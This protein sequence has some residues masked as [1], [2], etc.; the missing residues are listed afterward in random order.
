MSHWHKSFNS[1]NSTQHNCSLSSGNKSTTPACNLPLC[2]AVVYNMLPW[3]CEHTCEFGEVP[4]TGGLA[5]G[6]KVSNPWKWVYVGR[7]DDIMMQESNVAT[8]LCFYTVCSYSQRQRWLT[9]SN[10]DRTCGSTHKLFE[11]ICHTFQFVAQYNTNLSD[12]PK[13]YCLSKMMTSFYLS[14]CPVY[15]AQAATITWRSFSGLVTS[16]DC[17]LVNPLL[18]DTGWNYSK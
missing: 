4:L 11:N 12:Q 18:P 14:L 10:R 8:L 6:N 3:M 17:N 15:S 1:R 13:I 2:H 7:K 5:N 9:P 16:S